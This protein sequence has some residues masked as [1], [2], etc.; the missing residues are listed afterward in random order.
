V[1]VVKALKE[2][3]YT[4][5]ALESTEASVSLFETTLPDAVKPLALVVGNEVTGVD[6]EILALCDKAVHI[7]MLG[8]KH[9][10]NVS[11]AFGIAVYHLCLSSSH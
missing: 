7:P 2:Q 6:P 4:V 1:T 11:I 3:G 9:S 10:L 8:Y 5:F